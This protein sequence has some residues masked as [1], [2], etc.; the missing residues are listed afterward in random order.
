[1]IYII[2][3]SHYSRF[4]PSDHPHHRKKSWLRSSGILSASFLIP[5]VVYR[6]SNLFS[7]FPFFPHRFSACWESD[8]NCAVRAYG[9][10]SKFV[11]FSSGSQKLLT[12][13]YKAYYYFSTYSDDSRIYKLIVCDLILI[14]KVYQVNS[15]HN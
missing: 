7:F 15:I 2:F 8:W 9:C 14:V 12:S 13:F 11:F 3:P 6:S 4:S 5:L 10:T 1:M